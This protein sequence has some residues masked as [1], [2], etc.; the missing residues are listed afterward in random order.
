M[1]KNN[2]AVKC[3]SLNHLVIILFL[4]A[5]PLAGAYAACCAGHGGVAS[6]NKTTGVQMCKDGTASPTCTCP[7]SKNTKKAVPPK[8]TTTTPATKSTTTKPKSSWWGGK[9]K[10]TTPET[11]KG[12]STGSAK[13]CCSNHGGVA[14]CNKAT[15]HQMCKDGTQSPSC[16]CH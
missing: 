13:G 7:K 2:L 5:S 15:G 8:T 10:T 12:T 4:F 11:S 1:K 9:S 14:Q 3:I 16:T 6:C